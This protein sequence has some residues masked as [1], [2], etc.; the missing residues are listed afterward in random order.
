MLNLNVIFRLVIIIIIILLIYLIIKR[1]YEC[2]KYNHFDEIIKNID[3]ISIDNNIKLPMFTYWELINGA[4]KPPD[5]IELCFET[6]KKHSKKYFNLHILN[7]T[8]IFNYLP[9][10]RKDINDLPIT[11]KSDYIRIALLYEY[12]GMWMDA[13]TIMMNDFEY[14]AKL[15]HNGIDFIGFG[16]SFTTC[17]GTMGYGKPSNGVIG[18]VKHGKLIGRYLRALNVKL[19]EYFAIEK[20]KRESFNYFDLGKYLIWEEYAK[21]M[22]IDPDYRYYHVPAEMDGTRNAVGKW[23]TIDLIFVKPIEFKDKNKLILVML[24]NNTYCSK[25]YNWFCR[26]SRNDIL[27]GKFVISDLFRL[28]LKE[29]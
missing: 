19:N 25:K 22:T 18:S 4:S 15:L 8:T 9:N 28:A 5:Y 14:L 17:T 10:L 11:F 3:N 7:E 23:I 27:K 12:G 29:N 24:A 21:L 6:I 26:L 13:D 20:N 16:C 1:H 2:N